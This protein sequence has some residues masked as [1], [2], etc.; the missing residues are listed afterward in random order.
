MIDK[1]NRQR[2]HIPGLGNIFGSFFFE[3]SKVNVV[4]INL[5]KLFLI[6]IWF[7]K[8]H[9]NLLPPVLNICTSKPHKNLATPVWWQILL[10]YFLYLIKNR[11][12]IFIEKL[13]NVS[14]LSAY[15]TVRLPDCW[16]T[17][18]SDYWGVRL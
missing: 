10:S 9:K 13:L 15:W 14:S 7:S 16:T 8:P 3:F 1:D 11:Y 12:V 18:P 2:L 5:T 4:K 17:R 6:I